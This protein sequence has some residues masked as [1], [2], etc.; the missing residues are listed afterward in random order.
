MD[1]WLTNNTVA[2][3]VALSVAVMLWLVLHAE[4]HARP[5]EAPPPAYGERL[6]LDVPVDVKRDANTDVEVSPSKVTAH[7][8]GPLLAMDRLVAGEVKALADVRGKAAGE[9][10]VPLVLTGLPSG[11]GGRADPQSVRVSV[12]R[13]GEAMFGAHVR[14]GT[15]STIEDLRPPP[16][17][18]RIQLTPAKIKAYGREDAVHSIA[19]VY[20]LIAPDA[21]AQAE[22]AGRLTGYTAPLVAVDASGKAVA[23]RLEPAQ[24]TVEATLE[25]V[26]R[27]VPLELAID[28]APADGYAVTSIRLLPPVVAVNGPSERLGALTTIRLGPL[29]VDGAKADIRQVLD[30]PLP[31]G[32]SS[33]NP[34]QVEVLIRIGPKADEAVWTVPL[35]W[36]EKAGMHV[37]L[38]DMSAPEVRIT[39]RGAPEA[40]DA[41][42]PETLSAVLDTGDL[43]PGVY[44]LTPHVALPAGI[45]LVKTE[46]NTVSVEITTRSGGDGA[47]S[48]PT[49]APPTPPAAAPGAWPKPG[50][51]AEGSGDDG[52]KSGGPLR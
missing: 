33:V 2:K 1:K 23:V 13:L 17:G 7:L 46:P 51:P 5:Q 30:V 9:H 27:E 31:D 11:V 16:K 24:A 49:T 42:K 44:T 32:L 39:V 12:I 4:F 10:T 40:L 26:T 8:Y 6:M 35:H 28:G 18:A 48:L 50:S 15:A 38:K 25:G 41:L 47:S 34:K 36:S 22:K 43:G 21:W 14:I 52:S 45:E 37:E 29:S 20:A 3:I 19:Q